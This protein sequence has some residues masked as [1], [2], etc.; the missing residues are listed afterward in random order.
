LDNAVPQR[1][2]DQRPERD[3]GAERKRQDQ[4]KDLLISI[5]GAREAEKES[6]ELAA[7]RRDSLA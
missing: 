4:S 3:G 6:H 7:G 2:G 1:V 5:E